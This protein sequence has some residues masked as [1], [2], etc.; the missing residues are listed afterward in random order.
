MS[1]MCP[2]LGYQYAREHINVTMFNSTL[3]LSNSVVSKTKFCFKDEEKSMPFKR[4]FCISQSSDSQLYLNYMK[5]TACEKSQYV[6]DH[7]V[8]KNSEHLDFCLSQSL[9]TLNKFFLEKKLISYSFKD[10]EYALFFPT[11]FVFENLQYLHRTSI[12]AT[13][14]KHF[15]IN[16]N[17]ILCI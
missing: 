17:T 9:L 2:C 1:C 8:V 13:W 6:Y 3:F 15:K 5:L 7:L 12:S 4:S 11:D 14:M 16:T 10:T